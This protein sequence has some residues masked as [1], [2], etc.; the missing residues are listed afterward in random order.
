MAPLALTPV[1]AQSEREQSY[2]LLTPIS[3]LLTPDS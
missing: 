3:S 1:P 2:A